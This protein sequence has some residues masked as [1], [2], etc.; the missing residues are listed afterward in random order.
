MGLGPFVPWMSLQLASKVYWASFTLTSEALVPI[1]LPESAA[2]G[3]VS[4]EATE[5]SCRFGYGVSE[6]VIIQIEA[7]WRAAQASAVLPVQASCAGAGQRWYYL[8]DLA[9]AVAHCCFHRLH[10]VGIGRSF[11]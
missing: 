5:G 3:F 11:Q 9:S 7:A 4:P 1:K 8:I 10:V 6:V 2:V